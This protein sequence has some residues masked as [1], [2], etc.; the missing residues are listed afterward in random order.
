MD[1]VTHALAGAAAARVAAARPLGNRAWLAGAVGAWVPDLDTLIRS[2]A[3]PLLYAEFHRHFTHSLVFIPVGGAI[4][5]LPW[6]VR[7][8][9]AGRRT[10]YLGAAIAGCATHGV[11]DAATTWGTRVL[12][13]LSDARLAWN[14]ISIV[15]PLFT[16]ILLAGVV[17]A[18][19]R[20]TARPAL[21]AL[22]MCVAYL[23]LGALQHARAADAQARVA[24]ARGHL[25]ER[26]SVLPGFGSNIVWRSLYEVG[27]TLYVD[28]VRVP[29]WGQPTWRPGYEAASLR[30]PDLPTEIRGSARLCHDFGRFAKF[31]GG[32]LARGPGD[33]DVI[34]DARYSSSDDRYEP[35]WAIRLMPHAPTPVEW[36]D[37]S[38]LR[39]IDRAAAWRELVGRDPRY[40]P[41]P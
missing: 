21:I 6:L 27:G 7:Q 28:R 33:S 24:S 26:A 29:W 9:H 22:A 32:W 2:S 41:I 30:E 23:A 13:P 25:V 5:A 1:P 39:R 18:S 14:W 4:A 40:L 15:D 36:V 37:R 8:K 31:T 11:L 17:V 12:W 35:V 38:H 16:T 3:D 10:A 34:G 20:H 19:W